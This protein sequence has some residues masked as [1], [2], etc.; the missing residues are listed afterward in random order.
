M[1]LFI[2]SC[3]S[4]LL[5]LKYQSSRQSLGS[6]GTTA[7]LQAFPVVTATNGASACVFVS[8]RVCACVIIDVF[9]PFFLGG[10][11]WHL[12]GLSELPLKQRIRLLV[13]GEPFS[14]VIMF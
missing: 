8:V 6:H 7:A 12:S 10:L 5:F 11:R 14:F 4:P 2:F 3:V 9:L 13:T 1:F